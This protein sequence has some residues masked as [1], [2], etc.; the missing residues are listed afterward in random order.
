MPSGK[1]VR[2]LKK[3]C[4]LESCVALCPTS[5][6]KCSCL[7]AHQRAQSTVGDDVISGV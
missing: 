5:A 1:V 4:L 3:G 7:P 2:K 6:V